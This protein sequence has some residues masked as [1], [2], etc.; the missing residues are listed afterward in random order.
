MQVC[1]TSILKMVRLDVVDEVLV[2]PLFVSAIETGVHFAVSGNEA[3]LVSST[4][5]DVCLGSRNIG[6]ADSRVLAAPEGCS[7]SHISVSGRPL[8]VYIVSVAS[9]SE[10]GLLSNA[11]KR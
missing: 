5:V 1:L 7:T 8:G 11:G 9:N 2:D 10:V 6:Q 4:K 3:V